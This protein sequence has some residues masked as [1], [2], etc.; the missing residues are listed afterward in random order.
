MARAG[1]AGQVDTFLGQ[2]LDSEP[3][4]ERRDQRDTRVGDRILIVEHDL[5]R[6]Q[7][8]WTCRLHH[9]GDLL[10][11]APGATNTQ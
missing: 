7:S 2:L 9:E 5:D 10:S 6:V 1:A 8:D 4:R 3:L 11:Q